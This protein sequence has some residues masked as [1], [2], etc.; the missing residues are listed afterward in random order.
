LILDTNAIS[1]LFSG[2]TRLATVLERATPV[3]LPVVAIGEYRFGLLRSRR[4]TEL[5]RDL[6]RLIDESVLLPLELDTTTCYAE[7]REELRLEG[8]PIPVN[9]L[10]IAAL[11]RQHELPI[12]S[13]DPHFDL[14]KDLERRNW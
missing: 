5:E 7:I 6:G 14:V 1:D 9:D 8:R 2:N 4:R 10:W 11:A 12:V 3:C 13:R